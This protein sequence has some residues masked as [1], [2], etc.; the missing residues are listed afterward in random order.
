MLNGLFIGAVIPG[1]LPS[2]RTWGVSDG[3]IDGWHPY[4]LWLVETLAQAGDTM[5]LDSLRT[6][7]D[8]LLASAAPPDTAESEDEQFQR[9]RNRAG[10]AYA[11][12]LTRAVRLL[13]TRDTAAAIVELEA[14]S[15]TACYGCGQH[16]PLLAAE[17][18][19]RHDL[20]AA[21]HERGGSRLVDVVLSPDAANPLCSSAA[22]ASSITTS[23][24][25]ASA[26]PGPVSVLM[27]TCRARCTGW[28]VPYTVSM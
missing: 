9:E 23:P 20:E 27:S 3:R 26:T 12:A 8:S 11:E 21:G 25:L 7:V 18:P 6:R 10:Y 22:S 5:G 4:G 13:A 28:S 1:A 14:V 19:L 17:L 15:D 16:V 24:P 2:A